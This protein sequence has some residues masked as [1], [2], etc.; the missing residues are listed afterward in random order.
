MGYLTAKTATE[1]KQLL[2]ELVQNIRRASPSMD[3]NRLHYSQYRLES[4]QESLDCAIDN[5][6]KQHA[7]AAVNRAYYCIFHA[8]RAILALDGFDSKKHTGVIAHFR[9]AV[10]A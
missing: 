3:N 2:D 7:S 6:A 1:L 8:I 9:S 10:E 4:A 5:L